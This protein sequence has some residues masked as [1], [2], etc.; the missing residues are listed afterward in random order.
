M[1]SL[2]VQRHRIG[3]I[4]GRHPWVF[5]G[6]LTRIP[7]GIESGTPVHLTDETGRFLVSGYF[8]SYS[9]IAVRVWGWDASETVDEDFF[10]R[11]I[12]SAYDLRRDLVL[13]KKTDSCRIVNSESDLLP[14]LIVDKYGDYLVVQFHNRGIDR[15]K[16]EIVSALKKVLKPKGIYERS[17]VGGRAKEGKQQYVIPSE[18]SDEGSPTGILSG[19]IPDQITITENGYKFLVDVKG[20]QK[21]GFF[22]DQRDKRLALQKYCAGKNVLNCFSYTGGFSVYA[23]DA[24]AKKVVSVDTSQPAIDLAQ[25]NFKL[26]K[27]D[28][29]KCEF[30]CEDVKKYL[31]VCHPERSEGSPNEF[32]LIILDP[33]AFIKD[34]HKIHEGV[35]GYKKINEAAMRLL[36]AGGILVTASC[37]QHLSLT[38]FRYLLSES[39][40]RA[41][42][43]LQIL[44]TYTHG[45][46]HPQLVSFTEGEYLKCV[47]ARVN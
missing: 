38:D 30:V 11:R 3:P 15:W 8:N 36:P 14:G 21:T 7:D 41:G 33:P 23:L 32:D 35:Q 25:E 31:A 34:R 26:N 20:G 17:D 24:G 4:L 18:R 2:I 5:S 47:F 13:N 43:T 16:D 9:Q 29:K 1:L 37:S 45:I 40:A 27:L 28:T 19:K 39:A 10:A 46:D 12:A 6:A 22:L 44:E 42:R